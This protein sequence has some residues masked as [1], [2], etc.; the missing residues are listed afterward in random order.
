V[1]IPRVEV[2]KGNFTKVF[3]V[4]FWQNVLFESS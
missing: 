4:Q 1:R 3:S 2:G